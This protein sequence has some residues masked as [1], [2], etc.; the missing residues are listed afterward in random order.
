MQ[1]TPQNLVSW[2]NDL[3]YLWQQAGLVLDSRAHS[4]YRKPNDT[5][6]VTWGNDGYVL[7]K[8]KFCSLSEYAALLE[9]RQYS[10]LLSDGAIFQFSF[11]VRKNKIIKHRLCWYPAPID[12]DST[13]LELESIS[14]KILEHMN[15][16]D[17]E[18]FTLKSPIRFDF[19]DTDATDEH[20]AVHMHMSVESCRIPVRTPL[21]LQKFLK[22]IVENFYPELP[23]D[24][25]LITQ[26]KT[27][28]GKDKLTEIQ[29][30]KMHINII[31]DL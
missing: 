7:H 13:D 16:G 1:A 4:A 29:K 27:F 23:P 5:L 9:N 18:K 15:N 28:R 24:S 10:L 2:I 14:D 25:S 30:R 6:E 19:S 11:S 17:L 22:F 3:T 21:C 8:E 20:P 31:S 12:L 26:A